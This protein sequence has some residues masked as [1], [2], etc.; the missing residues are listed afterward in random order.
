[1]ANLEAYGFRV[2]SWRGGIAPDPIVMPVASTE[3]F[4]VNGGAANCALRKGD[5]VRVTSS[6]TLEQCDG[7]EDTTEAPAYVV[8]GIKQYYSSGQGVLIPS[9]QLPSD[10]TY[11]G[12]EQQSQAWVVPI[13][14]GTWK[15]QVDE[16]TT[17]TTLAAYEAFV[18]ENADHIL[19]GA[20]GETYLDPKLDIST[21][22]T[23][24]TLVFRIIDIPNKSVQKF[25]ETNVE[26]IVEANVAQRPWSS[27]TG[28]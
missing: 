9:K 6:G 11:S 2:H 8:M 23:T 10:V 15:I 27:A 3:S 28:V 4:D 13:E 20:S 21:H 24:D 7:N 14:A 1:M 22:N 19:T 16:N 17:A 18:G 25:D 26:L 5:L 12:A